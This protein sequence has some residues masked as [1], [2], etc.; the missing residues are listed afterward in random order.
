MFLSHLL[1]RRNIGLLLR[2]TSSGSPFRCLWTRKNCETEEKDSAQKKCGSVRSIV[3]KWARCLRA[4]GPLNEGRA[5]H[6]Y[7][8]GHNGGPTDAFPFVGD[9][10]LRGWDV[11]GIH[12]P[13][14]RLV[15]SR[16]LRFACVSAELWTGGLHGGGGPGAGSSAGT[17]TRRPVAFVE[18]QALETDLPRPNFAPSSSRRLR[19]VCPARWPAAAGRSRWVAGSLLPG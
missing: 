12:P 8:Q 6:V 5:V 4:I 15:I 3:W 11:V 19:W 17:R 7:R 18:L 9:E 16:S 14:R 1:I 2:K 10:K 13:A